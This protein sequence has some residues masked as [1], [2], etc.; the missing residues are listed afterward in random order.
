MLSAMDLFKMGSISIKK[1]FVLGQSGALSCS[2][3]LEDSELF[4]VKWYKNDQEFYRFMPAF[5]N[6]ASVFKVKGVEVDL[7]LSDQNDLYLKSIELDSKGAYKCEVSTEAP[8]FFTGID[9]IRVKIYG[10][11]IDTRHR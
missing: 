4:S 10:E 3:N 2:Y 8:D 6:R 7:E 11:N 5:E 1:Q 9:L